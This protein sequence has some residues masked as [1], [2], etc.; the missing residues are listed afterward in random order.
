MKRDAINFIAFISAFLL[1]GLLVLAVDSFANDIPENTEHE[2]TVYYNA[3]TRTKIAAISENGDIHI[4][5]GN[6]S[7]VAKFNGII[8]PLVD[9][10]TEQKKGLLSEIILP[11][12]IRMG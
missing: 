2:Y 5:K 9:Y 10:Y 12:I 8:C 7:V 4:I 1:S 11:D 6:E 3:K